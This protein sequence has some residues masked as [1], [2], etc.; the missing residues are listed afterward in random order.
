MSNQAAARPEDTRSLLAGLIGGGLRKIDGDLD[1]MGAALRRANPQADYLP[2]AALDALDAANAHTG[3]LRKLLNALPFRH[4]ALSHAIAG[5]QSLVAGL[6]ALRR[7]WVAYAEPSARY[8]PSTERNIDRLLAHARAELL[9][10]DRALGCP[11]GCPEPPP[12]P[13]IPKF[14]ARP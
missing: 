3:Q 8:N 13:K 6:T 1:R 11:W 14:G 7:R 10:A 5:L 2:I 9:A 4:P 12:A